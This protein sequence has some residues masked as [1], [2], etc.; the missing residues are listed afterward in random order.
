MNFTDS[1]TINDMVDTNTNSS[2]KTLTTGHK[3]D[4]KA[5][6]LTFGG[7]G[8]VVVFEEHSEFI[9]SSLPQGLRKESRNNNNSLFKLQG[10]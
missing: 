3:M 4:Q 8:G 7:W 10:T 1:Q 2:V 5:V 9:E 6:L